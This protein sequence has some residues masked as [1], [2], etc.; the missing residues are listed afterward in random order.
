MV[1]KV[2]ETRIDAPV[3]KVWDFYKSAEALKLLTPPNLPIT[4][5]STDNSVRE[6]ALHIVQTKI[7]GRKIVWKA[8]ITQVSPPASFRDTAEQSPFK[9]WTHLH[10]FIDDEGYTILRDTVEYEPPGGIFKKLVNTFLVEDRLVEVFKYRHRT[11]RTLMESTPATLNEA[12]MNVQGDVDHAQ[13]I[14]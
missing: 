13:L 8:R 9:S 2:F 12:L 1:K 6:G 14:E 7:F 4:L 5:L 11:T 3:Q 10:E